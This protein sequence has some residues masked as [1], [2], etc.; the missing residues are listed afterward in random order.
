[1]T[2]RYMVVPVC[3]RMW[4]R[5]LHAYFPAHG[6]MHAVLL[7]ACE[8][9]NISSSIHIQMNMDGIGPIDSGSL[10]QQNDY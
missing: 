8:L 6:D 2:E 4:I 10:S 5:T 7:S 3:E 1:M 9:K